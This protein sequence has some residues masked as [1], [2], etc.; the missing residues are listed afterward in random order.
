MNKKGKK[1]EPE[2]CIILDIHGYNNIPIIVRN[3]DTEI[4]YM[5]HVMKFNKPSYIIRKEIINKLNNLI[6]EFN[7]NMIIFE[8]NKLF[9]DKIDKHPDP[10]MLR[11]IMLGFGIKVS[12]EDNYNDTIPYI[13]EIPE[14]DWRFTILNKSVKYAID[15]YKAHIEYQFVTDEQ[16]NLIH[17][18]NYYKVICFSESIQY[19]S[20]M[21]KKY[22]INR[23][24]K[25]NQ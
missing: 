5:G 18:N 16:I 21:N 8:Q 4:L 9:I 22:Q 3:K 13:L 23:K 11:N 7:P 15:L 24:D 6:T 25:E 17:E 14:Q 10:L 20:L 19:D 1:I 12:I 2:V